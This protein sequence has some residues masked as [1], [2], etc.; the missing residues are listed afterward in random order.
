MLVSDRL[1][2]DP[3]TFFDLAARPLKQVLTD[4]I[5]EM[6][7]LRK[8]RCIP[9]FDH[10][11]TLD[12]HPVGV[13]LPADTPKA[14]RGAFRRND[15]VVI[16]WPTVLYNLDSAIQNGYIGALLL[17]WHFKDLIYRCSPSAAELLHR[18]I[19][20]S[21]GTDCCGLSE[22]AVAAKILNAEG[23][24][25]VEGVPL[26]PSEKDVLANQLFILC[27]PANPFLHFLLF[28]LSTGLKEITP[29]NYRGALRLFPLK[30]VRTSI[31][32]LIRDSSHPVKY[33]TPFI[34]VFKHSDKNFEYWDKTTTIISGHYLRPANQSTIH[35]VAVTLPVSASVPSSA[36][37]KPKEP[38]L[39]LSRIFPPTFST[40]VNRELAF[41]CMCWRSPDLGVVVFQKLPSNLPEVIAVNL[42]AYVPYRNR[43]TAF[44]RGKRFN[45]PLS[46]SI[47]SGK[48]IEIRAFY[49]NAYPELT[50]VR[51]VAS[52]KSFVLETW[53]D[54]SMDHILF[55]SVS[56]LGTFLAPYR[57]AAYARTVREAYANGDLKSP[58]PK[59]RKRCKNSKLSDF[60]PKGNRVHLISK[61]FP[62]GS[63]YKFYV[64]WLRGSSAR[65]V[66]FALDR[67]VSS[68]SQVIETYSK[69]SEVYYHK[70]TG[71]H[72]YP[73]HIFRKL[74]HVPSENTYLMTFLEGLASYN[75]E[76]YKIWVKQRRRAV[77]DAEARLKSSKSRYSWTK[78]EIDAI[79]EYY[80]PKK[81]REN[82][83]TLL[84]ICAGRKWAA[85]QAKAKLIR[86]E[87]LEAGEWDLARIP[88]SCVNPSLRGKARQNETKALKSKP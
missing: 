22:E 8:K 84:R 1:G 5:S 37:N 24:S 51:S 68:H 57:N 44:Y 4:F 70:L 13:S 25:M 81:V 66:W 27:K 31:L 80:Q 32:N 50:T 79:I 14:R 52:Y 71:R 29:Q 10:P 33:R 65:G 88:H 76:D 47:T 18:H 7:E 30:R 42:A 54:A 17:L 48:L 53:P 38:K 63:T 46:T 41:M 23:F 3:Q 39:D 12:L 87:M 86:V 9:C 16:H 6:T 58:K 62:D 73:L 34:S 26:S 15:W 19:F 82:R 85:I 43:F 49:E 20:W 21:L 78:E 55:L 64:M 69:R 61:T 77:V 28:S 40:P 11:V 56:K 36:F 2:N 72:F 83:D 60:R 59:K 35:S 67:E 45:C 74:Q 75:S